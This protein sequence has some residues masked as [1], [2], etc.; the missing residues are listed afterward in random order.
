MGF[1]ESEV[2]QVKQDTKESIYNWNY[3]DLD[4]IIKGHKTKHKTKNIGITTPRQS[5]TGRFSRN[6]ELS[7]ISEKEVKDREK[8][9]SEQDRSY[10][11][12]VNHLPTN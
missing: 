1:F 5:N 2:G 11:K 3:S 6:R 10:S 7:E 9:I 12:T 8:G 4:A